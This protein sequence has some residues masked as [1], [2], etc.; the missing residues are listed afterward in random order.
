MT[1]TSRPRHCAVATVFRRSSCRNRTVTLRDCR[2]SKASVICRRFSSAGR[3]T[4]FG[5]VSV[6]PTCV[7]KVPDPAQSYRGWKCG[8]VWDALKY[9][10][11]LETAYTGYGN[12]YLPGRGWGDLPQGTA[13]Q[14]PVP[15]QEMDSR[16]RP[17]YGFGGGL[18]SSAG[19]GNYGLFPGGIY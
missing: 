19:P 13:T 12:W 11:R 15:Y 18:P 4:Q 3:E 9:E 6:A 17:F 2:R 7:P 16:A 10:F 5:S 14:F 8:N 1:R